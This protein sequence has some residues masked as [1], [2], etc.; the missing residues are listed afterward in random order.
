M[1]KYKHFKSEISK[2]SVE[3]LEVK[4]HRQKYWAVFECEFNNNQI[5]GITFEDVTLCF[6]LYW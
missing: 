5:L 3:W 4:A 6:V 2:D 1:I